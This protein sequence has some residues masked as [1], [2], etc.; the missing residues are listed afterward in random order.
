MTTSNKSPTRYGPQTTS[1]GNSVWPTFLSDGSSKRASCPP[2][3][4]ANAVFPT[5]TIGETIGNA[6]TFASAIAVKWGCGLSVSST[7]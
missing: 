4:T 7:R 6:P 1:A 2:S 3:V 5:T